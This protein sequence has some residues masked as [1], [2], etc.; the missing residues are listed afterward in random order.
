MADG[1]TLF[2][3]ELNSMDMTI[4]PKLLKVVEQQKF[5]QIGGEKEIE[6]DVRF[7]AAMN[8]NPEAAVETGLLRRDLYYRLDVID[9]YIPPLRE[10]P[11]DILPIIDY[12]VDYYSNLLGK[13]IAGLTNLAKNILINNDWPGNIRELRNAIEYAVNMASDKYISLQELPS[14]IISGKNKQVLP[15]DPLPIPEFE[16]MPFSLQSHMNEYEK[17]IILKTMQNSENITSTAR[18]LGLTRQAL[19][20]KMQKHGIEF[21]NE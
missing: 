12:Y 11:E 18:K 16:Q 1:G 14:R 10:R 6:V 21:R 19:Q 15:N 8:V 2:L 9:L 4:Q 5:R 13:N 20:Y 17:S 3:D 7:I